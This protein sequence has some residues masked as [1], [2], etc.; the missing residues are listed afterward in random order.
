MSNWKKKNLC[1]AFRPLNGLL[2]IKIIFLLAESYI[3]R[4]KRGYMMDPGEKLKM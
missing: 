1:N 3:R 4:G 2:Q